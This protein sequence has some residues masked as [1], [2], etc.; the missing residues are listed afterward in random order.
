[1]E[2]TREFSD[3]IPEP[4]RIMPLLCSR[5]QG[6]YSEYIPQGKLYGEP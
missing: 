2:V 4:Y 5:G 1:M 3:G 6:P